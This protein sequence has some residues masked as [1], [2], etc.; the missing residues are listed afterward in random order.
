MKSSASFAP[1]LLAGFGAAAL[2]GAVC[3][4]SSRPAHTAGGPIAV[5]VA[6][7]PL[8]VTVAGDSAA[9]QPFVAGTVYR[10]QDTD[11]FAGVDT[12]DGFAAI[13]VPAGKRLIVQTVG[14]TAGGGDGSSSFQASI[15]ATVSGKGNYFPLP[16]IS[17][18]GIPFAGTTQAV[19]LSVDDPFVR[20]SLV[21]ANPAGTQFVRVAVYGYL[22]NAP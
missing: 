11:T 19:A 22:V 20:F 12:T 8:A 10:F 18:F 14:V 7:T 21:R 17:D 6:N 15:A 9:K 3:L 16:I 5:N 4:V 2:L 13:P 1:R